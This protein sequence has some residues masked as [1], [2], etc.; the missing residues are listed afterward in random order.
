MKKIEKF[1]LPYLSFPDCLV[2]NLELSPNKKKLKIFVD[3]AYL[4]INNGI[5]FGKGFLIFTNW[6]SLS[7]KKY[8]I[9]IK[10]WTEVTIS[11]EI[12]PLKDLC[13]VSF[14]KSRT[15][16]SGFS[17]KNI[18]WMEWEITHAKIVAEFEPELGHY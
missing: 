8:N 13:E 11:Q 4:D 2:E 3:G 15:I 10:K 6:E 1:L 12:D 5:S 7:I 9:K 18:D 17:K 14:T 16:L